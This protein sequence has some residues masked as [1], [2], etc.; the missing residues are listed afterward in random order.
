VH[1]EAYR[2]QVA[3][4][5]SFDDLFV[6]TGDV[7][8]PYSLYLPWPAPPLQSRE[9]RYWRVRAGTNHGSTDWSAAAV[10]EAALL[11]PGDAVARFITSPIDDSA[12]PEAGPAPVLRRRFDIG[13][14]VASARLYVT[15]LGLF[16]MHL[17]G[18]RVGGDVIAP[19][20]TAYKHRVPYYTYDV[21]GLIE[22]GDNEIGVLLGNG[23][24]RG[25]IG[26]A[27][28]PQRC[29]YGKRLALWAQLEVVTTGGDR[30]VV[31]SDPSWETATGEL[32]YDD[33]YNGC[34][35]DF[36]K[37]PDDWSRAEELDD[38]GLPRTF[39]TDAPPVRVTQV[40]PV[41]SRWSTPSGT[42]FDVGQNCVGWLRF[43]IRGGT[44]GD[45]I[46]VRHAEVLDD[47][48]RLFTKAL[49]SAKATDTYVLDGRGATVLEP[50]FT[51]HG[52]RFAEV[53]APA[54][55]E[56]AGVEAVVVHSDMERSGYFE[57]SDLLVNRL[58]ENIVWSQ[59]GKFLSIPTDCPQRSERLGWT[60]DAQ[61]FADTGC[62]VYDCRDFLDRWLDDLALDQRPDGAVPNVVPNPFDPHFPGAGGWGDAATVVPWSVYVA[63]GD[64]TT[65]RRR[66]RSMKRWVDWC[67][68]RLD[69]DGTRSPAGEG[70]RT[71]GRS[72]IEHGI[73][74]GDWCDPSAGGSALDASTPRYF[75]ATAYLARSAA[76]VA[77][78][79]GL[80]GDPSDATEY[81]ALAEQVATAAGKKWGD[82]CVTS[83]TGCAVALEFDIAPVTQ[84]EGIART[85]AELVEREGFKIG[86]GFLG[87]PLILHVL[88]KHGYAEHARSMLL[89]REC[90]SWMHQILQGATTIWERWDAI[91]P[92]GAI[93]T[94]G[95]APGDVSGMLSFNHYAFGAV[96]AWL[97][98]DLA[99]LSPDEDEPGYRHI[100]IAPHPGNGITWARA[101]HQSPYGPVTVHWQDRPDSFRLEFAIPPNTTAS[102]T[103]PPGSGGEVTLDGRP[104]SDTPIRVTSGAH[105]VEVSR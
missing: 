29:A 1:Q 7:P 35:V 25:H 3:R 8:S 91:G 6:D 95:D 13:D 75:M 10:V 76:L 30:I 74:F 55:A 19:D 56:I 98:R 42:M 88:T 32:R 16:E 57:C 102:V 37:T 51:F 99:G 89:Q 80:V 101:T 77:R 96:G 12:E 63:Y 79:A 38:A 64:A 46:T 20:W 36:R 84:R 40:R 72:I 45:E 53:T 71:G 97:V 66:L 69:D 5:V 90:P 62:F 43:R 26:F 17:N 59:R 33:F 11:D 24:Y 73:E 41:A 54:G 23:W 93:R 94:G 60:G 104:H 92:D 81:A 78:V 58:F 85:L 4:D 44:A 31:A 48:G 83:Q 28:P 68:G 34:I 9:I 47:E 50:K 100:R 18:K 14:G 65:L 86:T 21:T 2:I 105:V 39:P 67:S 82:E 70:V 22:Q 49:R 52:Y 27:D 61:V 103:L 87:T 15:A